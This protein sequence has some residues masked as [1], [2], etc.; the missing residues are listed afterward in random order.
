VNY[1]KT[2]LLGFLLVTNTGGQGTDPSLK[3]W[4]VHYSDV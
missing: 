3:R 4:S 1:K 2:F